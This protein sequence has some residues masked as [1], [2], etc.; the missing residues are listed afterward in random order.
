MYVVTAI[1]AVE[2]VM[3]ERGFN[4]EVELHEPPQVISSGARGLSDSFGNLKNTSR[5]YLL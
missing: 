4:N 1:N 5:L 2:G 3:L